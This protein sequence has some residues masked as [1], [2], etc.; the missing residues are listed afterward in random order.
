MQLDFDAIRSLDPTEDDMGVV[1]FVYAQDA[2]SH[3]V[4]A[5]GE[6]IYDEEQQMPIDVE[7]F[8]GRSDEGYAVLE[9]N[10]PAEVDE[11][12]GSQL[13]DLHITTGWLYNGDGRSD[14]V[15]TGGDLGDATASLTQCWGADH[16][17][18]YFKYAVEGLEPDVVMVEDGDVSACSIG[19]AIVL[20]DVNYDD[21]RNAFD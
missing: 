11:E 2:A 9:F 17:Q 1:T 7:Y 18:T 20:E 16:L 14:A 4:A 19:Q 15:V 8:Y 6:G 5:T 12:A 10:T 13:E 21:I 3:V